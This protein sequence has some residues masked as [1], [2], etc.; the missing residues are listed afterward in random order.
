[1]LELMKTLLLLRH[2][3]ALRD[4]IDDDASRPLAPEGVESATRLGRFLRAAG[5]V[6]TSLLTSPARRARATLA[7]V[8]AAAHWQG[9]QQVHPFYESTVASVLAELRRLPAASDVALAVG[10]EPTW[11]ETVSRL[12]GGGAIRLSTGS[13][14]CIRLDLEAWGELTRG[15]GRLHWLLAPKLLAET[16]SDIAAG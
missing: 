16:P 15:R 5:V 12:I 13:L 3:K 7:A 10:H 4:P 8:A 1:M 14:A 11:S 2:A 9:P 6:P